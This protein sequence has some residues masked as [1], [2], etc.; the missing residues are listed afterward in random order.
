MPKMEHVSLHSVGTN[1]KKF[2]WKK[3][4]INFAECPSKALGKVC[5]AECRPARRSA[6]HHLC[7]VSAPGARQR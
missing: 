7:Q 2:H 1:H 6:K 5:F 4:E 3:M